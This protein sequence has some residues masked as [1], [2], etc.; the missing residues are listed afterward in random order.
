[1]Q[2]TA[3]P[4]HVHDITEILLKVAFYQSISLFSSPYT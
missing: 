1:M 3:N 2:V 4:V